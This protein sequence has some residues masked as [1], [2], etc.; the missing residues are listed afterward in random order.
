MRKKNST[1]KNFACARYAT[2]VTF[3]QSF[4]ASGSV[5]EGKRGFSGKHKLYGF[6]VEMSVVPVR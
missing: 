5:Q 3:Q 6:K 1:I 2:D 4:R